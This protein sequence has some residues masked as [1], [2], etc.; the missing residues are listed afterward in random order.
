MADYTLNISHNSE[1]CVDLTAAIE[2]L[3]NYKKHKIGQPIAVT[4]YSDNEIKLLLAIGKR[5]CNQPID[6]RNYGKEFYEII[7]NDSYKLSEE[8][9]KPVLTNDLE[10]LVD[11][12]LVKKGDSW[13]VGTPIENVITD[14]LS[15]EIWFEANFNYES[16]LVIKMDEPEISVNVDGVYA[17][18]NDY[19]EI[20]APVEFNYTTYNSTASGDKFTLTCVTPNNNGFVANGNIENKLNSIDISGVITNEYND[21]YEIEKGPEKIDKGVN[22]FYVKSTSKKY[23]LITSPIEEKNDQLSTLSN[24]GNYSSN[25]EESGVQISHKVNKTDSKQITVEKSIS[26]NGDYKYYYIW[27]TNVL[28]EIPEKFNGDLEL[29][30]SNWGT[31]L[32]NEDSE[33]LNGFLYVLKPTNDTPPTLQNEFGADVSNS[34]IKMEEYINKYNTKYTLYRFPEKS[35]NGAKYKKLNL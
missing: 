31:T 5:D 21:S 2:L 27:G 33:E 13:A 6:G 28:P 19:F 23:S 29:F 9:Y 25:L 20:G 7:N 24:K 1:A 14:I 4:Y 3:D 17:K 15:K 34:F 8:S 12:G 10:S 11:V 18:D 26:I 32:V 22:N 35:A 30:T 16:N